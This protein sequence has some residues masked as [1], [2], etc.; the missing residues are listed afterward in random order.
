MPKIY[1]A[2]FDL[3]QNKVVF[4]SI[5]VQELWSAEQNNMFVYSENGK[6]Y[7]I[8]NA[9]SMFAKDRTE[10]VQQLKKTIIDTIKQHHVEIDK[11]MEQLKVVTITKT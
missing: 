10:A 7:S 2:E 8:L 3:K 9:K 11:L 1:K 5:E 6:E 4:D